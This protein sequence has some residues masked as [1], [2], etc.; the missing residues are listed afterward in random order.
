[1]E[2]RDVFKRVAVLRRDGR[3]SEGLQLLQ[4]ALRRGTLD[5]EGVEKAGWLCTELFAGAERKVTARILVLAQCTATWFANVLTGVAWGQGVA[6][7]VVEG[8]YDNVMQELLAAGGSEPSP[9]LVLLLP[10]NQR[11]LTENTTR[12]AAE[13]VDEECA[14]W[15]QA[16]QLISGRLGAR[17]HQIGYDWMTA[18]ALGYGLGSKADGAIALV[19]GVNAALRR[20][21]P[22]QAFFSAMLAAAASLPQA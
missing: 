6:L 2:Q 9:D 11:L 22:A 1:M 20:D 4:E 16:W 5:S 21:L 14:F 13:R 12:P 15:R 7:Q 3:F 18:G 19:R 8:A 17:I 10:W